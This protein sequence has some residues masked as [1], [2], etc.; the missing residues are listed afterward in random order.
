MDDKKK[1]ILGNAWNI[2]REYEASLTGW[3]KIKWKISCFI[4]DI[5][6]KIICLW[7]KMFR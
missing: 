6:V 4:D 1:E 3:E 7:Y 2:I 5:H